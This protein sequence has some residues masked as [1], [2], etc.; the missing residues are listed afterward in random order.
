MEMVEPG[1]QLQRRARD[2]GAG[3]IVHRDLH[4]RG[5]ELT[6]LFHLRAGDGD[7]AAQDCV[8]RTRA[9]VEEATR[10]ERLVQPVSCLRIGCHRPE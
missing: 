8:A 1:D 2:I 7:A 4:R 6:G 9:A 3:R 10:D 5:H